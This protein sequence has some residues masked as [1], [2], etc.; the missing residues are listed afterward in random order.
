MSLNPILNMKSI[1]LVAPASE[2]IVVSD[3]INPKTGLPYHPHYKYQKKW[4]AANKEKNLECQRN[5]KK[6]DVYR[7]K[8]KIYREENK[9]AIGLIS[10]RFHRNI[11]V[12]V[13]NGYGGCC[14][15]CGENI[16]EFLSVDHI[17]NN[18]GEERRKD[19]NMVG[20]KIYQYLIANNFPKDDYQILC[21]NCN[22]A[23][24]MHGYCPHSLRN[25]LQDIVQGVVENVG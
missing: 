3:D 5:Y 12:Q 24:G 14:N 19:R 8:Q 18:G 20:R 1:P 10:K 22:F 7:A 23:K 13:V 25:S 15:C 21:M 9:D 6:N 11:K 2:G 4:N 16:L 17:H